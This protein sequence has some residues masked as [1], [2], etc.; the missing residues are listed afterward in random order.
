M[1]LSINILYGSQ[2]GT[3]RNVA[4]TLNKDL[5]NENILTKL[6]TL[7][8]YK[9]T[10]YTDSHLNLII[11]STTGDGEPPD[12]AVNF[13][14][15]LMVEDEFICNSLKNKRYGLLGLGDSYFAYFCKPAK[16]IDAK[17]VKIG[18]KKVIDTAFG[19]DAKNLDEII[20]NWV[21]MVKLYIRN[22]SSLG[23]ETKSTSTT[24]SEEEKIRDIMEGIELTNEDSISINTTEHSEG[25]IE[26]TFDSSSNFSNNFDDDD[27]DDDDEAE[28]E[29]IDIEYIP[30]PLTFDKALL[31]K[32]TQLKHVVKKPISYLTLT[33]ASN[34]CRSVN[35]SR[36]QEIFPLIPKKLNSDH[37]ILQYSENNPFKAKILSTQCL[38]S[39]NALKK[40]IQVTMDIT[41]LNWNYQPGY[42]FGII[43][44]NSDKLV[45]PL[46]KRLG[47]HP[48]DGFR[49]TTTKE[50]LCSG[51]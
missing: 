28:E 15:G 25:S 9:N 1:S 8:E 48:E 6:L 34:L 46:L 24:S 21:K 3:A 7:N 44:P 49:A 50:N 37:N 29:T 10:H 17:L 14:N 26:E 35:Y 11:I 13:Y 32:I 2:N 31:S 27:D 39:R 45:L 30:V 4:E 51:N 23:A 22:V 5:S 33:S 36:S 19:D 42:A 12:N 16:D 40:T 38:T 47:L 43:A 18:S 20:E 41:G